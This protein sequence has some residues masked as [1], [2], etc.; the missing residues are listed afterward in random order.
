MAGDS[1]L[2]TPGRKAER[3]VQN[4]I[5]GKGRDYG[6]ENSSLTEGCELLTKKVEHSL[7]AR[8]S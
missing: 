6:I 5:A 2:A 1:W 8:Q 7:C 4:R 3:L